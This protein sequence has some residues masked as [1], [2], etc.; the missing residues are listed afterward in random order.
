MGEINNK[1]PKS[2]RIKFIERTNRILP[3]IVQGTPIFGASTFYTYANKLG[4]ACYKSE[5]LSKVAQNPCDSVQK[6]EL[7]NVLI[8]LMDFKES[9]TIIT[10]LQY[11]ERV[12]L[13]IGN[14]WIMADDTE[15]TL[16]IQ[17][18]EI[19]RNRNRSI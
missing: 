15:L 14:C 11:I 19:I 17:L 18:Q 7:Y 6:S 4:K 16:F 3:P 12:V 2:K 9:L 10:D 8:I 5:N 13:H 1:Y